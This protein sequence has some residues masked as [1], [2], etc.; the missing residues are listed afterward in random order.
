SM[1]VA[2]KDGRTFNGTMVASNPDADLAVIKVT[3]NGLPH[4]S[5]GSSAA[6]HPGQLIVAIGSPLGDFPGSVVSG[7]LSATGVT[8]DTGSRGQPLHLTHMLQI[9]AA[10]NPGNSGGPLFDAAGQVVGIIT[11]VDA[12][13]QGIAFAIPIDD[14]KMI[15]QRSIESG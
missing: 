10:I 14:A 12:G 15:V 1:S 3:A 5:L 7:I 8:V 2:L 13:G 9:D 11:A 6:L 4:V